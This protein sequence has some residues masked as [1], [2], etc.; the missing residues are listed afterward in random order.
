MD[1]EV[2][3]V[4]FGA[5]SAGKSSLLGALAQAAQ[6]QEQVLKGKLSDRSQKLAHLHQAHSH[7]RVQPT[8][9]EVVSYPVALEPE[10]ATS[11][12]RQGTSEAVLIDCSGKSAQE[13]LT[14]KRPWP[15]QGGNLAGAVRS[16]DTLILVVDAGADQ[17]QLQK[18]FGHLAN[19]VRAFEQNRSRRAEVAGLPVYLVLS[20]CDLLAR[21]GDSTAAWVQRIEERK[22]QVDQ[23]FKKFLA[24]HP[25]RDNLAFGKVD[26][27]LWA[28]AARRPAL[29]DRPGTDPQPYGVAE[30]FRQCLQDAR[31]FHFRQVQSFKR[32]QVLVAGLTG[33]LALMGILAMAVWVTRP[34]PEVISL[35]NAL[36][37]L[38]PAEGAKPADRLKDPLD[39]KLRQLRR[40]QKNPSFSLLPSKTQ[41]DVDRYVKEIEA[42]QE[43][44]REFLKK[45]QDPRLA[46]TEEELVLI[47][48]GV[49]DFPSP[50][51][52]AEAWKDTRVGRRSRL[53]LKDTQALRDQSVKI[54]AWINEQIQA[55]KVLEKEGFRLR[56]GLGTAEER[57]RWL[58]RYKEYVE[59]PWPHA[60]NDRPPGAGTITYANVYQ[61]QRVQRARQNWDEFKRNLK[62]TH[63]G[64]VM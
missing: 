25:E 8:T 29:A 28:T 13:I 9:E 58:T 57:E 33:L 19:F 20:K 23:A 31:G 62:V 44:N 11:R 37:G 51:D 56:A 35:E 16:A 53:W 21:K 6:G 39:D 55:G 22:R 46:T 40:I 10:A 4:L 42:Y 49:N 38:L 14:G 60:K 45:V 61:F 59:Q 48:K 24:Q 43:Y 3:L 47:E 50:A 30:L 26:L 52:Y 7:N 27:H 18:D 2:R 15:K 54:E 36:H 5:P 12:D 1:E 41:A 64:L 63:D 34:S 17:A 32:L